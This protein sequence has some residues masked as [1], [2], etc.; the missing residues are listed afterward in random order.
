[1]MTSLGS[2][3]IHANSDSTTYT[4]TILYDYC[5]STDCI[6]TASGQIYST[7]CVC[8]CVWI[9]CVIYIILYHIILYYIT[10][11]LYYIIS[12]YIILYILHY[13][14]LYYIILYYII[15]VCVSMHKLYDVC[16]CAVKCPILTVWISEP[17]WWLARLGDVIGGG[18]YCERCLFKVEPERWS[19]DSSDS[20][21]IF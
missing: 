14:I 18:V 21:D 7:M 1:M 17:V 12:H 16:I 10:F 20:S 19:I 2:V 8:V 11:I 15:F 9:K 5:S 4:Y 3:P 13:I 6:H